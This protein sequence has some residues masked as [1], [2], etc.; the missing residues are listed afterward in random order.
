MPKK[1][2]H[3]RRRE[4]IAEAVCRLAGRQGLDGVSLRQVAAEAGLGRFHRAAQTPFNLVLQAR[5]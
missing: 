1:V 5:R 3:G 4:E 2:D